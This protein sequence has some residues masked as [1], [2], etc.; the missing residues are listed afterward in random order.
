MSYRNPTLEEQAD[1]ILAVDG[2]H[3]TGVSDWLTED[4]QRLRDYREIPAGLIQGGTR[5]GQYSRSYNPMMGKRPDPD[6]LRK[7]DPSEQLLWEYYQ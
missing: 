6:N 3:L 7:L 5:P 2:N 4:Q 1:A